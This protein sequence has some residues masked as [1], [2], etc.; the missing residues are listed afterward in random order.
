MLG[1]QNSFSLMKH[2]GNGKSRTFIHSNAGNL[3]KLKAV[4]LKAAEFIGVEL[5][6]KP[7][8]ENLLDSIFSVL[9][10]GVIPKSTKREHILSN[11]EVFNFTIS[12]DDMKKLDAMNTNKHYCWDPSYVL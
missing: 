3:S 6:M 7:T 8:S 11:I 5:E 9:L 12:D 10:T 2:I 4:V 1:R